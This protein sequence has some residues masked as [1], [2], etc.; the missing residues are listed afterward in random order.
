MFPERGGWGEEW[1]KNQGGPVRQNSAVMH[2]SLLQSSCTTQNNCFFLDGG[3]LKEHV[4]E[5]LLLY[6]C[7]G[8]FSEQGTNAQEIVLQLVQCLCVKVLSPKLTIYCKLSAYVLFKGVFQRIRRRPPKSV[9]FF[10]KK[11]IWKRF[12][13]RQLRPVTFLSE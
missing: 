13:P 6:C 3:I 1:K 11:I 2:S 9:V 7:I 5:L 12:I 8:R 4:G 10:R